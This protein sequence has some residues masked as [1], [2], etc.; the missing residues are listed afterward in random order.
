MKKTNEAPKLCSIIEAKIAALEADI[1]HISIFPYHTY[2][3]GFTKKAKAQ[4]EI[5]REVLKEL[6]ND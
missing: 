6:E 1:Q 4:I 3:F 2:P 5:L